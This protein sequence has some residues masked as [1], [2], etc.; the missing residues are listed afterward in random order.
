MLE[1]WRA[2]SRELIKSSKLD[3]SAKRIEFPFKTAIFNQ[4]AK[5]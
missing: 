3:T 4:I 2:A 5:I 1:I